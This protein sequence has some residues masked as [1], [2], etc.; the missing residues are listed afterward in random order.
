MVVIVKEH[1]VL[2]GRLERLTAAAER[3]L[4]TKDGNEV[5]GGRILPSVVSGNALVDINILRGLGKDLVVD[6]AGIGIAGGSRNIVVHEH[7]DAFVGDTGFVQELVSVAHIGLV[8]V[9]APASTARNKNSPGVLGVLLG[10]LSLQLT[11]EVTNSLVMGTGSKCE[12]CK[13]CK[14]YSLHLIK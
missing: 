9:V 2:L 10:S 6:L 11:A 8:T 7:D 12:K 4:A 1:V 5:L 14:E 13:K 3:H